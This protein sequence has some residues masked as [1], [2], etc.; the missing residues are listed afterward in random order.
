MIQFFSSLFNKSRTAVLHITSPS[1]LHLRP[2][3]VFSSKAK[4]FSSHIE[5]ET[6]GK[7]VDAKNLNALLSLSLEKGDHF[8]LVCKG[9]DAEAALETLTALFE[10]LM[11]ETPVQEKS[12]AQTDEHTYTGTPIHGETVS[13]GIAVAPLWYYRQYEAHTQND[14]TFQ[15]AVRHVSDALQHRYDQHPD[16]EDSAIYLAQKE[17]LHTLTEGVDSVAALEAALEETVETLKGGKMAA[18][19]VDYRDVLQRIKEAMGYHTTVDYPTEAFILVADDLLPSQIDTLPPH[20]AGVILQKSTQTSHTAILLRSAPFPSMIVRAPL[21]QEGCMVILDTLAGTVISNPNEQDK[22]LAYSRLEAQQAVVSGAHT[23]RFEK[24][25]T[26]SGKPI[27]ILANVADVESAEEAK[28]NGAEGIGL[29]RTEFLF[30]EHAPTLEE[31]TEAYRL[32]FDLF[33]DITVRT[34]DVGGDKALPYI[35]LPKES[36]PFLGIRGVRLFKTHPQILETQLHAIF[37]ATEG[38][39]LKIMFPMVSTPDEFAE[40]KEFAQN[41]A[42]KYNHDIT[43]VT[44]GMMVEVPAVLF[45]LEQFNP[46]VDFYSIGTNDLLQYLFAIERT[47]PTLQTDP[48]AEALFEALKTVFEKADKPVSICGELAAD[49]Q[50][51]RKLIALGADTLSVSPALVSTLKEAVRHV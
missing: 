25:V 26:T 23:K 14:I 39:K 4:T 2:A 3:A 28:A 44:F 42:Q 22:A 20:T 19:I 41:V 7:S 50:A 35:D 27:T 11:Q 45:T 51:T 21:P 9:K 43:A 32:I 47:H 15:E 24:A 5:A 48:R 29:L 17:L 12:V 33:D 1:G 18:K 30:K 10:E 36:N 46:L 31:Q 38:K 13:P 49:T 16:H 40:A 8:D 34:L 37:T 6:R